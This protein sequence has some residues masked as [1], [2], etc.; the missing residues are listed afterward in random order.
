MDS[1]FLSEHFDF[2]LYDLALFG[3]R[4]GLECLS[5][6]GESLRDSTVAID[7]ARTHALR[8]AV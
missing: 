3:R 6:E 1:S 2:S 4:P 7:H 8:V 5:D